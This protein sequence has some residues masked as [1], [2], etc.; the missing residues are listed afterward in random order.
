MGR[1]LFARNMRERR[2]GGMRCRRGPERPRA[3]GADSGTRAEAGAGRGR[4]RAE[5]G[6][7]PGGGEREAE[8]ESGGAGN[9]TYLL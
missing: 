2:R 7:S 4:V 8:A 5:A 9:K 1:K 3:G 6:A